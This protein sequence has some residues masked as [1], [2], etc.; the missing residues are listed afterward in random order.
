[1]GVATAPTAGKHVLFEKPLCLTQQ[2]AES[3]YALACKI[4]L[5]LLESIK[6]AFFS[7]ISQMV[8]IAQSGEI[9]NICSVS[10]TCIR[11]KAYGSEQTKGSNIELSS[12]SFMVIIKLLGHTKIDVVSSK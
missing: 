10:A 11:G 4:R 9:G 3:L 12:Y 6:T 1:M 7:S 5:V 2:E 8:A